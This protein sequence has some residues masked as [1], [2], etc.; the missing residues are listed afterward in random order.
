MGDRGNIVAF[1]VLAIVAV[2]IVVGWLAFPSIMHFMQN[3][4]CVASG[5]VNC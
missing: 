2:V 5:H 3:Q 1:I 4:D